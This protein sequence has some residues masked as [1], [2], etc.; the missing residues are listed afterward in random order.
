MVVS[1]NK[2][3]YRGLGTFYAVSVILYEFLRPWC[4]WTTFP[5]YAQG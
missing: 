1:V 5:S 2:L 4:V 3:G